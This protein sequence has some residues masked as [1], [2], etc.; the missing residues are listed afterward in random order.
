MSTSPK[1]LTAYSNF[2]E[3]RFALLAR[4]ER[5]GLMLDRGSAE[6][7]LRSLRKTLIGFG[8]LIKQ[9][10]RPIYERALVWEM[11]LTFERIGRAGLAAGRHEEA[12]CAVSTGL[13]HVRRLRAFVET[14]SS[15]EKLHDLTARFERLR[16]ETGRGVTF[17]ALAGME[18]PYG[19]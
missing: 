3:S 6:K 14:Q 15:H 7:A 10:P 4:L 18:W 16:W 17:V 12:A 5:A 1:A 9:A 2:S 8:E 13:H 19:D 11:C